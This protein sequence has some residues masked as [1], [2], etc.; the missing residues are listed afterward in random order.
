M[1]VDTTKLTF[2]LF[3]F[4]IYY[5]YIEIVIVRN[6]YIEMCWYGMATMELLNVDITDLTLH[7]YTGFNN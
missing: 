4:Y 3:Y 1:V 2:G 5:I 7:C 6:L